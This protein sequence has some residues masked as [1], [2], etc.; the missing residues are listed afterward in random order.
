MR[1]KLRE[2]LP[3]MIVFSNLPDYLDEF[4]LKV[5]GSSPGDPKNRWEI[6]FMGSPIRHLCQPSQ[7][8]VSCKV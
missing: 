7:G 4:E 2:E 5:A 3:F 1:V 8:L 6:E